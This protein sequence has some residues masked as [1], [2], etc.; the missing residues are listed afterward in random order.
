MFFGMENGAMRASPPTI[1]YSFAGGNR[2]VINAVPY[3][4]FYNFKK[5]LTEFPSASF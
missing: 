3:N 4:V 5:R 2:D 1:Y